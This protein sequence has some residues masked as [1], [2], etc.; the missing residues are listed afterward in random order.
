MLKNTSLKTQI[1]IEKKKMRKEKATGE[2]WSNPQ[3]KEIQIARKCGKTFFISYDFLYALK[4][5]IFFTS[6]NKPT[7]DLRNKY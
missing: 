2:Q 1:I 6:Q 3:R 7:I 5:L 4:F